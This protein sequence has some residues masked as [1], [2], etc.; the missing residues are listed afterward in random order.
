MRVEGLRRGRFQNFE[1]D[2]FDQ[3]DP[4]RFA[5]MAAHLGNAAE[6]WDCS[7]ELHRLAAAWAIGRYW[8]GRNV[9]SFFPMKHHL[10]LGLGI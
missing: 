10:L 2:L 8:C 5:F 3:A 7:S 1:I 9:I 6:F 4:A